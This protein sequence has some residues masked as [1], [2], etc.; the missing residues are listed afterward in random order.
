MVENPSYEEVSFY[1]HLFTP[2][3]AKAPRQD[4]TYTDCPAY[5][6]HSGTSIDSSDHGQLEYAEPDSTGGY[7]IVNC[8]AYNQSE[9][10][11]PASSDEPSYAEV[12]GAAKEEGYDLVKC[13]AYNV[14]SAEDLKTSVTQMIGGERNRLSDDDYVT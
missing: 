5:R 1:N 9:E 6:K 3:P 8:A 2:G 12:R 10:S 11:P 4:F 14:M 13:P 7:T